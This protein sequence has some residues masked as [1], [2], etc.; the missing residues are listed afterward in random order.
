MRVPHVA[1]HNSP[2][3]QC[4]GIDG[5]AALAILAGA[6]AH[7]LVLPHMSAIHDW[8][9]V[10][11]D[12]TRDVEINRPMAKAAGIALGVALARPDQ[13]VWVLDGDG[14]L[15]M[16]LGS[17]VTIANAAPRNLLQVVYQN[18]TYDSTGGQPV[19][20][21]ASVNFAAAAKAAGYNSAF[22]EA[23]VESLSA[24]LVKILEAPRPTL[25]ALKVAPG[26][27]RPYPDVQ[28]TSANLKRLQSLLAK[29]APITEPQA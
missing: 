27:P 24:N 26:P 11:K 21:G 22:T 17:L 25:L 10:S 12:K 3:P 15:L 9:Q 14:S 5:I 23:S 7:A 2:L 29:T 19:P 8:S 6:R 16:H 1:Q 18:G 13:D 28:G 4:A 20:S